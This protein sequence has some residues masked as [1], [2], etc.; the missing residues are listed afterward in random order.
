MCLFPLLYI[1]IRVHDFVVYHFV[2]CVVA[3]ISVRGCES[4]CVCVC[5]SLRL[6]LSPSAG[7]SLG[8]F[9]RSFRHA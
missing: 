6:S 2:V 5:V 3:C 1:P 8:V 4:V 7:P 9:W